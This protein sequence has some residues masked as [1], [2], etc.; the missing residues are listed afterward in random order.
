MARCKGS[1]GPKLRAP[2]HDAQA[3]EVALGVQ[4]LNR[5]TGEAKPVTVRRR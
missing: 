2:R 4:V 3:G 1:I 5:M